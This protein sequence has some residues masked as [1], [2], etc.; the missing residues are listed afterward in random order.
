VTGLD[1][2]DFKVIAMALVLLGTAY[3][4]GEVMRLRRKPGAPK[5]KS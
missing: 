3:I 5:A 1:L 4:N 2:V